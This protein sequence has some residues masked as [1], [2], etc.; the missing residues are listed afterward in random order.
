MY[1]SF[2]PPSGPEFG[3]DFAS[4][5][6]RRSRQGHRRACSR[7]G[8]G[9]IN[10]RG[11]YS[12]LLVLPWL[13]LALSGCGGTSMPGTNAGSLQVSPSSLSF[14]AVSVG[15]TASANVS[16]VNLSSSPVK[17]SA[18]N[19]TGQSFSVKGQSSLPVTI[20]AAGGTYSLSVEFNPSAS[21]SA[22]GQLTVTSDAASN[23]TAVVSLSGTGMV[24]APG[25][26]ALS[27]D[28][29]SIVGAGT[30]ACTVTLSEA[31]ASGGF[32]VNLSSNNASVSVPSTVTV[33]AGAT[34]AT[35]TAT[36][37]AVST[38]QA[39]TLTATAGGIS[40]SFSLEVDVASPALSVSAT[41]VAFGNVAV[42]TPV[43]QTLTLTSTGAA[44]LTIN[45]ATLTGTGFTVSGASFPLSLSPGDTAALTVQF[46]PTTAGAASGQLTI[47]SN[48]ST[49]AS[50]AIALSGTG[51]PALTAFSCT[52]PSFTGAGTDACTV[53][54]NAAAASG[55][56]AVSL[57]SNNSAV[58][59]PGT[60]TVAAGA[61]TASF[62]ATITA[63]STAQ[64]V[65]LTATVGSGS[66]TFSLELEASIPTLGVSATSLAFGSVAVGTSTSETLTLSS[67]GNAAVTVSSATLTGTG[68]SIS[69]ATFPLTL[70]PTQTATL[71]VQFDPTVAGASAGQ[72]TLASNSSTGASTSISLSGTGVPVLTG[73]SCTYSSM[74]G[75]GT[76][77][78]TVTL[79]TAAAS[80]GFTVSLASS[81]SSVTVP[82]SVTVAAA[83][84]TAGFS[85]TVASVSTAQSV[86]L[87]AS[88]EGVSKTFDL[89]L[90]AAAATLSVNAT[91]IAFGDV[92]LNTPATQLVILTS[93]GALPVIVSSATITGTGF[94]ISGASFPVTLTLNQTATLS[95]EFDPT[96]TGAS[97]GQLT[98]VSDSLT[99][100]TDVIGLSGTGGSSTGSGSYSVNLT[101]YAPSV[102]TGISVA[103]Y[104]IYR[105]PS[106]IWAYQL[107]NSSLDTQTTYS[108]NTVQSGQTYNYFVET[109]DT[110]GVSSAP[111]IVATFTIP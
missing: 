2:C 57:A 22:N 105:A 72:L 40:Q 64:P 37:S 36:V 52:D 95:V 35:F 89:E 82:T 77:A 26:N 50:T 4:P 61:T 54:I 73:L 39:V 20:A 7:S 32:T 31:A 81:S 11:L 56:F 99:N 43:T 29:A 44:A 70:T 41:S 23:G 107:L 83:A 42:N 63:V 17:I 66:K 10:S 98:I 102:A 84:T 74:T 9:Q 96:T 13:P 69:G 46:D 53:T 49:G 1:D 86:T 67:T 62:S 14:G 68:Y 108:D 90:N 33:A 91:S 34:S 51:M 78:C 59:V 47:A 94:S 38:A 24:S 110:A 87:T 45:S 18:L 100:P 88:V 15:K 25:L 109:V 28:S 21:G 12:L 97:T 111:S 58:T 101:W 93:T 30:D 85:A 65:T 104:N 76:D 16:L 5:Q 92:T 75:A 79:N 19:V 8:I 27:C 55:G 106:G 103:G 3:N 48:S 71:T 6:E 60:V 80:G